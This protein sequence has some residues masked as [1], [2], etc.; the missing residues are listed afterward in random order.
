MTFLSFL[1]DIYRCIIL[2]TITRIINCR[3]DPFMRSVLFCKY[4]RLIIMMIDEV[5]LNIWVSFISCCKES[6]IIMLLYSMR[7]VAMRVILSGMSA[8]RSVQ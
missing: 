3:D 7:L 1:F 6:W 4:L 8:L 5:E 2:L